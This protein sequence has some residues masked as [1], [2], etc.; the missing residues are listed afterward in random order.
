MIED[1]AQAA[2]HFVEPIE[3]NKGSEAYKRSLARGLAKRA[4]EIV[5][6]RRSG[7]PAPETHTYYG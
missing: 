7:A 2:S 1:I 5:T 6:A 3:D 4:F